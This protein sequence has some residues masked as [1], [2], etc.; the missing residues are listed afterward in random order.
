MKRVRGVLTIS[1]PIFLILGFCTAAQAANYYVD[2]SSGSDSSSGTSSTSP[3]QSLNKVNNTTF[4]AGDVVNFKRGSVWSGTLQVKSSGTST[5]PVTY[6]AYGTGTAPQVK[7]PTSGY[8]HG[9]HVS[10]DWNVIDGFLVTDAMEAGIFL[11]SGA[12]HNIVR[13]NEITATGTGVMTYGQ[14]T[15]ITKNYAHDLKMIVNDTSPSNDYG[16]TCYWLQAPNNEVSYNRGINCRAPSYDFGYDGGFVE[17]FNQGDNSYI[18]HNFAQNT[19]GFFELGAGGGGSAQNVKVAYNVMYNVPL[20]AICINNGSYAIN[21][22]GFHFENNTWISTSASGYQV[23]YCTNDFSSVTMRN[24]IFYSNIKIANSTPGTHSNNLYYMTNGSSV[25]YSLGSGEKTGNP[26]FVNLAT[27]DAHLTALS[28]AIDAGANLGYTKDY[29][30]KPVPQG[31]AP[32]IGACE[33]GGSS[34]PSPPTNL[35]IITK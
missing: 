30:D 31:A 8:G 17:V 9:I 20:G 24:N 11:A 22:A 32:D 16:A 33:Y 6:Q 7:G 3:W 15:L 29:D 1:F 35:R 2:A 28:P 26:L 10:G 4:Q 21:T 25:G 12:D 18:H 14:Y 5:N 27:G 19:N 13:N 34:A 23:F